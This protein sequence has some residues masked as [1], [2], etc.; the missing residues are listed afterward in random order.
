M[1]SD[2]TQP[3]A[4]PSTRWSLVALAGQRG[5]PV[6]SFSAW[7]MGCWVHAEIRMSKCGCAGFW[8]DAEPLVCSLLGHQLSVMLEDNRRRIA[9][10][11]RDLGRA[12][13]HRDPAADAGVPQR[14]VRPRQ[15]QAFG[16]LR[17]FHKHDL[18]RHHQPLSMQRRQPRREIVADRHDSAGCGLGLPSPQ[19]KDLAPQIHRTPART[20]S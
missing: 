13:R 19:F 15:S 20:P 3:R 8:H 7:G 1:P 9:S 18:L 16:K 14:I 5:Q 2:V 10:L 12:L 4:F 17:D 6:A 11:Q